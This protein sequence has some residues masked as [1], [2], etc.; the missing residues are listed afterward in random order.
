[1][2]DA[3]LEQIK[4]DAA[5]S[6][7]KSKL[8][9]IAR[10]THYNDEMELKQRDDETYTKLVESISEF[11][12]TK[13]ETQSLSESCFTS[14]RETQICLSYDQQ[15]ELLIQH[16]NIPHTFIY[17]NWLMQQFAVLPIKLRGGFDLIGH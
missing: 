17:S 11:V 4:R 5:G 12:I 6:K 2:T 1:M 7:I 15:A 10:L 13:G 16:S 9:F 14:E 3:M 8:E